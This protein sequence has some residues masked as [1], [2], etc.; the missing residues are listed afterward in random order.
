MKQ[1]FSVGPYTEKTDWAILSAYRFLMYDLE[2]N[3][4]LSCLTHWWLVE[5][6]QEK[7]ILNWETLI[8][9]IRTY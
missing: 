9:H 2:V 5:K 8:S 4:S 6:R 1:D 7:R 3:I